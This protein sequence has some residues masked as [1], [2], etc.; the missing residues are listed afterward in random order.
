MYSHI[1]STY[2][3]SLTVGG[4]GLSC[5]LM[6]SLNVSGTSLEEVRERVLLLLLVGV[7]GERGPLEVGELAKELS[8]SSFKP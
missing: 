1:T 8:S 3:C 4:T 6:V 5:V 7:L 2:V